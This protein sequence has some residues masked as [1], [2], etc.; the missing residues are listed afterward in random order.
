MAYILG[1]NLTFTSTASH[2]NFFSLNRAIST[3]N[4]GTTTKKYQDSS[5]VT[6]LKRINAIGKGVTNNLNYSDGGN[7]N[8]INSRLKKTR[9]LGTVPP[10]KYNVK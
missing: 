7:Q 6:T 2:N 8:T 5:T 3:N 1:N 9:S 10:K 4:S